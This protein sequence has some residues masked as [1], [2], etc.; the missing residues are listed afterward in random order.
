MRQF[1]TND[2][3]WL[4]I[5]C[6]LFIAFGFVDTTQG[7]GKDAIRLSELVAMLFTGNYPLSVMA[8]P[9]AMLALMGAVPSVVFGWVLQAII[10]VLRTLVNG[11]TGQ[12]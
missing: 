1:K 4:I 7:M 5:S 9:I 8:F 2:R 6:G 12:V 10:G 11:A 3:Q